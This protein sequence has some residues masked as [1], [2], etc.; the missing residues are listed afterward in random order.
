M[1]ITTY[2]DLEFDKIQD[3]ML[4]ANE[5][6]Y[7]QNPRSYGYIEKAIIFYNDDTSEII[8]FADAS[9]AK[10][11]C[12]TM[13]E[14]NISLNGKVR[15]MNQKSW[16]VAYKQVKQ[17]ETESKA[18]SALVT[19]GIIAGVGIMAATAG[20]A[21]YKLGNRGNEITSE[22]TNDLD[23]SNT[24]GYGFY[25]YDLSE[26]EGIEQYIN[27]IPDSLQKE[28]AIKYL[29]ILQ[30]F[31]QKI[32]LVDETEQLGGLTIEQL[33]AI[34]AFSN[35]NIY[36][37]EDYV[38]TFG[39]YNFSNVNRDFQ[40]GA[41]VT[42]AYLAN[43]EVDGTSLADIFKDETVKEFYLKALEHQ[44]NILTA[45]NYSDKKQAIKDFEK[46]MTNVAADQTSG[47]YIDFSMHPGMSFATSAVIISLNDNNIKLSSELVS[48]V[49]VIGNDEQKSKL[50][51]VCSDANAKLDEASKFISDMNGVL[52]NNQS[53]KIYNANEVKQANAEGR[54]P[55]LMS[56]QYGEL[57]TL[58]T[59]SLCDQS[60]INDLINKELIKSE[61]LVTEEDQQK[62]LANGIEI[63]AKARTSTDA[64]TSGKSKEQI[65]LEEHLQ[66]K[67]DTATITKEDV[68]ITTPE[69]KQDLINTNP[70]LVAEAKN[71]LNKKENLM[72]NE[73]KEE[74]QATQDKINQDVQNTTNEGINYVN[75][76]VSYYEN[77]GNVNGIPSELQS[78]YNNLGADMFNTCK[79][80]GVS[81][82]ETRNQPTTGGEITPI[83]GME[84]VDTDANTSSNNTTNEVIAPDSIP[85]QK[86]DEVVTPGNDVKTPTEVV[87][88]ND[89][90]K[91]PTEEVTTP[92]TVV[93][94]PI[95]Q[96]TN[97]DGTI[98]GEVTVLP[99]MEDIDISDVSTEV[100]SPYSADV[101]TDADIDAYLNTDE[102]LQF[103]ESMTATE[104]VVEDVATT[105]LTR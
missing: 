70:E 76:V 9:D 103:L 38:K 54:E 25:K 13:R 53:I 47:E 84:N 31:N 23:F 33:I 60:Q 66:K 35:S 73:T 29:N 79:N 56:L 82:W 100:I 75:Q 71:E 94:T 7:N 69:Q 102:G 91:A 95:N 11:F 4:G 55:V 20:V 57:D 42:G 52:V 30:K 24:N 87:T 97:P 101:V 96:P 17:E 8:E 5:K 21:G 63:A 80:T 34:D 105:G 36:T 26:F 64:K 43:P 2:N 50:D 92:G 12:K 83:P 90:V 77:N 37:A 62:I 49:V 98:G 104:P 89:E 59:E 88:P 46:F 32:T 78:A 86:A 93:D 28:N 74:Q 15:K 14:H 6:K 85:E 40:Q 44:H 68:K 10:D 27:E 1:E 39:L 19:A 3:V 65:Y 67:G 18:K 41:T 51:T 72:A 48:K 99:G 61:Q 58:L 81:R 45:G 16:K 22:D